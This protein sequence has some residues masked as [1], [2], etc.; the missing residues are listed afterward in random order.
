MAAR[1]SIRSRAAPARTDSSSCSTIPPAWINDFNTSENDKIDLS[2]L[3]GDLDFV[4]DYTESG[5]LERGDIA[6]TREAGFIG[7]YVGTDDDASNGDDISFQ[8]AG[9]ELLDESDFILI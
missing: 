8:V 6:Y 7:Y 4:G 9:S 2:F 3:N 5:P 1:A